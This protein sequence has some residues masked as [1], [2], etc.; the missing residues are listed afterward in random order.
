MVAPA[1]ANKHT[2]KHPHNK[3]DIWSRWCSDLRFDACLFSK[4]IVMR[5]KIQKWKR[6]IQTEFKNE[7]MYLWTRNRTKL[8][9]NRPVGL[10]VQM[11]AMRYKVGF[12]VVKGLRAEAGGGF[13]KGGGNKLFLNTGS[14]VFFICCILMCLTSGFLVHWWLP[15]HC[16]LSWW[17]GSFWG[18]FYEVTN[19]IHQGSAYSKGPTTWYHYV[20]YLGYSIWILGNLHIQSIANS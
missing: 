13:V 1:L 12:S 8:Q 16:V 18:L 5:D 3:P 19:S 17:K 11:K 7:K 9:S 20:A 2:I 15:F 14:T 6:E 4:H 10:Q